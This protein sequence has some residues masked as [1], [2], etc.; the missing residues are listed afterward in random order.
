MKALYFTQRALAVMF[1]ALLIFGFDEPYIAVLTIC[2]ALLHECGHLFAILIFTRGSRGKI[3]GSISGFRIVGITLSYREEF[4]SALGGPLINLVA[5]FLFSVFTQV[6]Y[7]QIFGYI[8]LLTALSNLMLID[9]YDGYRMLSSLLLM[10]S[11]DTARVEN[12]LSHLS[13]FFTVFM[14]FLSLFLILKLGEGYWIFAV[15][16]SIMLSSLIKRQKKT[17]CE[18]K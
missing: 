15:F 16:F 18:K 12:V 1:W 8:N 7:G 6:E 14:T 17:N 9:G 11:S 4:F 3:L 13:F 2:T 10:H 5:F